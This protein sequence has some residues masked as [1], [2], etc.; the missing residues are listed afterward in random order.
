MTWEGKTAG[1]IF[2]YGWLVRKV[3]KLYGVRPNL[4][5]WVVGILLHGKGRKNII[6]QT[7]ERSF[8][9]PSQKKARCWANRIGNSHFCLYTIVKTQMFL[10]NIGKNSTQINYP[11]ATSVAVITSHEKHVFSKEFI[12]GNNAIG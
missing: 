7:K 1:D 3:F 10:S 9:K 5:T 2:F 4:I 12:W 11:K 6:C 8:I